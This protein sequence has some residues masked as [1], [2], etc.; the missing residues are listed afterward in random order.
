MRRFPRIS[1]NN[2]FITAAGIALILIGATL[3]GWPLLLKI[4]ADAE[5]RRL[6]R[7]FES[8]NPNVPSEQSFYEGHTGDKEEK[9]KEQE[10]VY[11]DEYAYDHFPPTR[12]IIPS[13]DVR[14]NVVVA[15]DLNIFEDRLN[16][17]P[18]YYADKNFP[19]SAYPGQ[20][21]NVVIAGH[22]DGPAGYFLRLNRLKPGDLILLETPEAT[23]E[24]E[25]LWTKIVEPADWSVVE[26]TSYNVLTLTTCQRVGTDYSAKR[27][28]VRAEQVAVWRYVD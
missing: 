15:T 7:V 16:Y 13:L 14:V 18:G 8:Y 9:E 23:F 3:A 26:P 22:R 19:R 24:Y 21:G 4:Q 6:D 20:V 1:L 25:V 17:P 27:L 5:Q 11:L 12:I 28:V 10:R 2:K